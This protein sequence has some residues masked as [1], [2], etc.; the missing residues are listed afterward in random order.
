MKFECKRCGK[1]CV[2]FTGTLSA[3]KE[4]ILR[5]RKE[6]RDDIIAYVYFMGDDWGDLFFHPETGGEI[7]DRCPFLRKIRN[8]NEYKCMIEET[9]PE[10]CRNYPHGRKCIKNEDMNIPKSYCLEK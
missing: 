9:K 1:C 7:H 6:G 2:K 3:T 4:D 8:K 5:W 10:V